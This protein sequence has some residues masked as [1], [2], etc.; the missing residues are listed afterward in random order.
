MRRPLLFV[1]IFEGYSAMGMVVC[2]FAIFGAMGKDRM[3][4]SDVD[5]FV[6]IAY[7]N[8]KLTCEG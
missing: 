6:R 1:Q 4:Q 7:T 5:F 2:N 3:N 8:N